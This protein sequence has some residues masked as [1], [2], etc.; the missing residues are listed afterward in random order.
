MGEL[1]QETAEPARLRA[2]ASGSQAPGDRTVV[3]S[4]DG[5]GHSLAAFATALLAG[6]TVVASTAVG[7]VAGAVFWHCIGFWGFVR[8]VVLKGP[9]I[10]AQAVA[11]TGPACTAVMLDRAGG[12]A[13]MASCPTDASWLPETG[14]EAKGDNAAPS[15]RRTPKRWSVTVQAESAEE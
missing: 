12:P 13:Q 9:T 15:L 10:E 1:A 3:S 2:A 14:L 11:Q 5:A 6:R 4:T 8:D 7:F